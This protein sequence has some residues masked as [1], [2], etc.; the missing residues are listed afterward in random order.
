MKTKTLMTIAVASAF[1]LSAAAYAESG[2]E[3]MTPFASSEVG[4]NIP[5]DKRGFSDQLAVGATADESMA[6]VSGSYDAIASNSMS[7]PETGDSLARADE[8]IYSDFY[9]VTWEPVVIEQWDLYVLDT[10]EGDQLASAESSDIALPTHELAL[11]S[12]EEGNLDLA[13]AEIPS[14]ESSFELAATESDE[15]SFELASAPAGDRPIDS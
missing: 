8:G 15:S 9:V 14:D 12:D 7:S 3:V 11:V 2:H 1:G 13:F 5:E 6:S 4:E 10:G